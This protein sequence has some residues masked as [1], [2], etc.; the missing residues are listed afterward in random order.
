MF[1]SIR[2]VVAACL[3]ICIASPGVLNAQTVLTLEETIARTRNQAGPVAVARVRVAEGEADLIDVSPRFRENPIVEGATGPRTG[4]GA[5]STE[6]ELSVLQPVETGGQRRARMATAQATIERL[7]AEVLQASRTSVFEA[8]SAFL[9]GVA[10]TERLQITEEGDRVARDL[11]NST[12][13]RYAFGD[14]AAIDVNLARIEASK[15]SAALVSARADLTEAVGTLRVAL[16]L[17]PDEPIELRGSLE[18]PAPPVV[19]ALVATI[20]QRPEFAILQAEERSG[21]AQSALGRALRS[22]DVG[23]RLAY[24]R[25]QLDNIFLGGLTLSFPA[26]QRGQ[27]IL[28][29]GV[30]QSNTARMQTAVTRDRIIAEVRTAYAVYEQREALS[31]ALRTSTAGALADNE[32]LAR[33]SYETGEMSLMNY[34][35]IRRDVL[36]TRLTVIERRLDAAVSRLA[37][38]FAAGVLR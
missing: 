13:R 31:T 33:R 32:Q 9:A 18:L 22:P 15:A 4:N 16:R 29:R 3:G 34:L 5:R 6:V 23:F 30:A 7:R 20:D 35:L 26:F 24:E 10:A 8:A 21:L 37:V 28:A 11:L 1:H 36:D 27:G 17:P 2:T 25:D 12:E 19:D 14:V 38:D